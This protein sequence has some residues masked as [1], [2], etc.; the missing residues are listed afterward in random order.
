MDDLSAPLNVQPSNETTL[1]KWIRFRRRWT[2]FTL[3]L[4]T[5]SIVDVSISKD[6]SM[7]GLVLF[8][9]FM[10]GVSYVL[11]DRRVILPHW[12]TCLRLMMMKVCALYTFLGFFLIYM[13]SQGG[14][15]L[16]E[17]GHNVFLA[18]FSY[19]S[20]LLLCTFHDVEV[21]FQSL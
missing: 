13:W 10:S 3:L 4:L 15:S 19:V 1:S 18:L 21:M 6:N 14:N 17:L 2:I 12:V 9:L 20:A 7:L 11:F 16:K 8:G 5:S